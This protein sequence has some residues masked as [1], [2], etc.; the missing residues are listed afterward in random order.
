MSL[1]WRL[2]LFYGLLLGVVLLLIGIVVYLALRSSL[3]DTLD[4]DLRDAAALAATQ[5]VG[6]EDQFTDAQ[7]D[8]L[9]AKVSSATTLVVYDRTG[10]ITDRIGSLP[11]QHNALQPGFQTVNEVRVYVQ[12]LA[13]GGF[14]QALRGEAETLGVL[15][16]TRGILLVALPLFLLAGLGAGYMLADRALEPV[17]R[18]SK[19][20]ARIAASGS[21]RER[22]PEHLGRDEMARL[23]RAVNAMLGKLEAT[24][25]HERVFALAAAHE[26][27][28]PLSVLRGRASLTLRRERNP[29]EYVAATQEILETSDELS[30]LVERLL[31]LA[32]VSSDST[33][34][35]LDLA[36]LARE[37]AASLEP[38]F[39]AR[40]AMLHCALESAPLH[41]EA[42]TLR[43]VI[44]NLLENALKYGASRGQ[45]WLRTHTRNG[46]VRLEVTDDGPGVPS[47][48]LE[49]L[50]QPFQRGSGLQG[51]SGAGL[52]LALVAAISTAHGGRL[53]LSRAAEGG[54]LA[55]VILPNT[56]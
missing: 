9:Q 54:L 48:E 22:V 46:E 42:A 26:L 4:Q 36:V 33:R 51:V 21:Y 47:E 30:V 23:T 10:R 18:V 2:T 35:A 24:I 11:A 52:G 12:A 27:R 50:R 3:H 37:V 34:E 20:A 40:G 25:E 44:A 38:A 56:G 7:T 17:D 13:A 6:E 29:A 32:R 31:M 43:S 8:A 28:T 5:L 45:T 14:V 15:A 53:E 1:R 39:T 49:R 55:T 41:G 16:R 19:I